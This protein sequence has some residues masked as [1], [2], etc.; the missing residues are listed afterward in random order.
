M[1]TDTR[2]DSDADPCENVFEYIRVCLYAFNVCARSSVGGL[3]VAMHINKCAE[4]HAQYSI[5]EEDVL[6][7]V[8]IFAT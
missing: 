7:A 3:I 2:T 8:K 1:R 4:K 5:N 6:N